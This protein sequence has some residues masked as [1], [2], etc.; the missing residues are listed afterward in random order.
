MEQ[1]ISV[2]G[3]GSKFPAAFLVE[4]KDRR[5]LLDMGKGPELGVRPDLSQVGKVDAVVLYALEIVYAT[6]NR[7]VFSDALP[8]DELIFHQIHV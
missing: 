7:Y 5:I 8:N 3:L 4:V 6:S 2:S 1:L